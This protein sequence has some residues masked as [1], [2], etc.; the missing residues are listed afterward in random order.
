MS[1]EV[2]SSSSAPTAPVMGE[3]AISP[4]ATINVKSHVPIMLDLGASNYTKWSIFFLDMC[5]KF[6][7]LKHIDGTA[8]PNPV[9]AP[10]TQND[11][12]VRT[13]LYGS[14]SESVLDFTMAPNQTAR[15]LWVA[16]ENHFQANKAP[17]SIYLSHEFHT[18]TQGDLSVEDYGKKMKVAADKLRD[19]GHPVTEATLVLN[20]LRGI[21]KKFSNTADFVAGQKNITFTEALDQFQLKL[22]GKQRSGCC[23]YCSRRFLQFC[24]LRLRLSVILHHNR[25]PAATAAAAPKEEPAQWWPQPAAAAAAAAADAPSF[26]SRPVVLF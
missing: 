19:V 13:W 18:M 25:R 22:A 7:L 6:G 21:N 4:F 15:Q 2:S 20:L 17:R 8:A 3:V 12:C 24:W 10:Y 1:P 23:C 5:G 11:F 26:P 9:D 16:I 14:V